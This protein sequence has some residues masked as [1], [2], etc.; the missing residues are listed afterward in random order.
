MC[1]DSEML[2]CQSLAELVAEYRQNEIAAIATNHVSRWVSQF[3]EPIR[4]PLLTELRQVLAKTYFSKSRVRGLL[5][6]VATHKATI[7]DNP[8]EFWRNTGLLNIQSRGHSQTE[9][10]ALFDEVLQSEHGL[11]VN[12]CTPTAGR[13][14][15][16]DDAIFGGGHLRNDICA[17]LF[18]DAPQASRVIVIVLAL[19]SGGFEFARKQI[20]QAAALAGKKISLDAMRHLELENRRIMKDQ[21]DVLWPT[22]LPVDPLVKEYSD[23]LAAAGHPPTLRTA[24]MMGNN[25]IFSTEASRD[26]LEQE[27]LKA[28]ARIRNVCPLLNDYQRPLGNSVLRT[29][30]FG[31]LIVTYRNCPN[32]SPLALWASDP[33]YALFP[34]STN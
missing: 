26:L 15:Y 22:R 5:K 17:W 34:R 27:L 33:W 11:R 21:S 32:N 7:G 20:N 13:Y 19:H 24:G 3:E 18:K 8:T 6:L 4:V 16:H 1:I 2:A 9:M 10:L 12:E 14:I 30:G 31:S 23:M 28:G 25:Q 29:L